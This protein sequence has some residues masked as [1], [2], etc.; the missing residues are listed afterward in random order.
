MTNRSEVY[1]RLL[2]QVK[3]Y[4]KAEQVMFVTAEAENRSAAVLRGYEYGGETWHYLF[5]MPAV[6][7]KKGI[8]FAMQEGGMRSPA[9]IYTIS[10]GFGTESP[11]EG[12]RLPYKQTSPHDYWVDDVTSED[13]NRW[14]VYEGDPKAR[15]HSF[16]RLHIPLYKYAA[17]IDYNEEA[18]PGKGSA[19]FLHIWPDPNGYTAGCTAVS[20]ENLLRL[21]KWLTPEKHSVIIQGSNEQLHQ[22]LLP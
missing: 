4:F 18:I 14:V 5:R 7:G 10:Q 17:V 16:E 9:G 11:P 6:I 15:W 22:L 13:Y 12:I 20:E 21:L 8:T 3:S 2:E 1:R 19:I